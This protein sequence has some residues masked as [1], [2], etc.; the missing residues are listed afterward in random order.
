MDFFMRLDGLKAWFV[1]SPKEKIG[2]ISVTHEGEA[3]VLVQFR[4]SFVK[5]YFV[6]N[7]PPEDSCGHLP[8][9]N[10]WA[11]VVHI[12][13]HTWALKISWEVSDIR[14]VRYELT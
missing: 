5:C 11:D 7:D 14:R 6:D 2:E 12:D 13:N 8:D 1:G 9:D 10:M 3:I 4:P